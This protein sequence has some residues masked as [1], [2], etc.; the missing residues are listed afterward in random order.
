MTPT[1]DI[2]K[3][4]FATDEATFKRAVGLYDSGKVTETEEL[5]GYY[6]A[7]VLGTKPYRVS[8]S[9][10]NYKHGSC[11]C[12]IGQKDTLCKHMVALA[13]Y[14]VMNGRPLNNKDKDLCHQVECSRRR[15]ASSKEELDAVKKSISAAMR[16]IK[17]YRGP[18]RTWFAYQDSLREGCNRL[19]TI[20]SDLPVNKQVAEVLVTLLLRL[21]KK[22]RVGGV[23]DSDG[24]VG[25]FMNEVVQML[26]EYAQIDPACIEAFGPLVGRETC[27]GW[28]EPLVRIL[29]E[30]DF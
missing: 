14:A 29:D 28:E 2:N 9:T 7:V 6:S 24:T 15:E 16:Y 18:S 30:R 5:G 1:Y 21:D 8:V 4:K 22:L 19:A 3:I 27:F 20:V 25:G 23:D 26:E 13:L 11:T 17:P 10:R 12:Y